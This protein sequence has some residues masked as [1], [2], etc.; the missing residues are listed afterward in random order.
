MLPP[1]R[2]SSTA[3][4][5]GGTLATERSPQRNSGV[6][7]GIVLG[8]DSDLEVMLEAV[9]VLEALQIGSEVVVASA[10]RTPQRTHDYAST[11][12]ARGIGVLIAAAGGAAALPGVIAA[13]SP[14]PVIG[15]PIASTPLGGIDALLSIVQMPKGVPVATVAIGK[16]GAANA[17]LLAAQILSVGDPALAM[18]IAAYRKRLA[19]EVD[20]RARRVAAQMKSGGPPKSGT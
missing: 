11:A 3:C 6:R 13:S 14:L 18:R 2:S 16:W 1:P 15:V 4:T 10:H 12:H 5:S 17:G 8:S 7:V 19:D 20:E 9:K